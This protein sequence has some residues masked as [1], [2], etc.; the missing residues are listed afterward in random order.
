V[1]GGVRNSEK[2]PKCGT[3]GSD[4]GWTSRALEDREQIDRNGICSECQKYMEQGVILISVKDGEEEK[5]DNP[6]R[7]GC[8]AVV[9]DEAIKKI[10]KSKELVDQIIKKRMC[11]IPDQ[12]WLVMGLPKGEK[13]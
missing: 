3:P 12:A 5:G 11:Y 7:T 10:V 13:Q 6:Y 2:C 1:F 4:R 8:F 9:K